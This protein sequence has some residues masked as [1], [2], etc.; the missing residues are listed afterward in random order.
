[1][2]EFKI[3]YVGAIRIVLHVLQLLAIRF[4]HRNLCCIG[5]STTRHRKKAFVEIWITHSIVIVISSAWLLIQALSTNVHITELI[6]FEDI[7]QSSL[8][9]CLCSVCSLISSNHTPTNVGVRL[10]YVIE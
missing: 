5:K 9:M 7:V 1:M 3:R 4:T 6:K 2:L 8:N 10:R